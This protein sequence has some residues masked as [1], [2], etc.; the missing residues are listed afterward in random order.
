MTFYMTA[1]GQE[2]APEEYTI[3]EC[4]RPRRFSGDTSQEGGAWHLWF[5]LVAKGEATLLVF[6][7]RLNPGEDVG[8]IGP[9]WEYYLDRLV[10]VTKGRDAST[11]AWDAYFPA[12]QPAYQ[13]LVAAG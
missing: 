1:E 5:E 8:S 7:Q 3:I 11:I 9:G 10:A 4:D 2:P 6:G 13:T 12:M